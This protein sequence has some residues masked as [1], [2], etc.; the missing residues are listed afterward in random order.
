MSLPSIPIE[1]NSSENHQ[2]NSR[3]SAASQINVLMKTKSIPKKLP[4]INQSLG[5]R[6]RIPMA[7]VSAIMMMT[8]FAMSGKADNILVNPSFNSAPLF[9]AAGW[10]QHSSESW[11]S[12]VASGVNG[13]GINIKLVRTGADGL[14][15][16][17][18]YGNGAANPYDQSVS[19]TVACFPGNAYTADAWYSAYLFCTNHIGGDDGQLQAYYG[20]GF[21]NDPRDGGGSGLFG[22]SG[23]GAQE[24]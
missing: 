20:A 22:G 11:S 3:K 12:G 21:P 5:K 2:R 7:L 10:T 14:W 24:D 8:F 16:Q 23:P 9:T 4:G 19:Q 15:M 6:R 1:F 18:T 13:S 17:G